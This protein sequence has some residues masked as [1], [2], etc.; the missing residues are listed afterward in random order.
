MFRISIVLFCFL[1]HYGKLKIHK[2][3]SIFHLL[4]FFY[5]IEGMALEC[6]ECASENHS[7][8]LDPVDKTSIPIVDCKTL[9]G[10]SN[11]TKFFCVS[12]VKTRKY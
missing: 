12:Y 11:I 9:A 1:A 5:W 2:L 8:C 6:Y 7:G 3:I 4:F 10:Q